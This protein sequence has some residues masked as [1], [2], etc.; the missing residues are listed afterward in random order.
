MRCA[1]VLAHVSSSLHEIFTHSSTHRHHRYLRKH[2]KYVMETAIENDTT[3][4]SNN[5]VM[6]FSLLLGIDDEHKVIIKMRITTT[7]TATIL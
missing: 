6:D 4:L 7:V 3:F 5:A 2:C 1:F